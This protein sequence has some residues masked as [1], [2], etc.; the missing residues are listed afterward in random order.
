MD[1]RF[2]AEQDEI[3]RTLREL[4]TKRC[5]PADVRAAV[6]TPAGHD[7]ALWT[8]LADGLGLPALALPQRYGGVGCSVTDLA[9]ACEE[10]GSVPSRPRPC[11][12][13][14]C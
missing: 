11:S 4:L 13:P 5:T 12:R 1:A 3:R 7:P 14:P 2:T 9:L 8:A 6:D 10:T